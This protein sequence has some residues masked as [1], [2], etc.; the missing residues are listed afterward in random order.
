MQL[1]PAAP[2]VR[3]SNH[4]AYKFTCLARK[5]K[6]KQKKGGDYITLHYKVFPLN[7]P[8]SYREKL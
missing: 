8:L 5:N 2:A 7:L 6:K 3:R 4:I 1:K